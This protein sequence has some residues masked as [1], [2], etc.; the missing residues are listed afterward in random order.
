MVNTKGVEANSQAPVASSQQEVP[1]H[2]EALRSNF[3]RTRMEGSKKQDKRFMYLGIATFVMLFVAAVYFILTGPFA[4]LINAN[5]TVAASENNT[6]IFAHPLTIKADGVDTSKIDIFVASV[7]GKPLSNKVVD[8]VA[9]S[10]QV[11]P[12]KSATDSTG[13]V[14]FNLTMTNQEVSTVTF[15]VDSKSFSRK[16]TV[17]GE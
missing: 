14:S 2:T 1:S 16:V 13:H 4:S 15:T 3:Q 12:Q 5:P 17:K 8:V 11:T 10:G 7:D 6:L 9:S